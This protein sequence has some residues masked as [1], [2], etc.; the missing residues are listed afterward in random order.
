MLDFEFEKAAK[1]QR[2]AGDYVAYLNQRRTHTIRL[3]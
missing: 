2:A 1:K 3:T